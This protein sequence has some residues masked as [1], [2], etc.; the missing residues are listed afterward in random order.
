M[1]KTKAFTLVEVLVVIVIL[2]LLAL[3][4]IPNITKY[5][6]K[7]KDKYNDSLKDEL[8]LAGK[9]FYTNNRSRIPTSISPYLNDYVSLKELASQN[10]ISKEFLDK[11]KNNC[12]P[13]VT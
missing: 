13:K 5:T 8:L 11:N 1:K 9:D 2:A 3:L 4:I 10:Y 12:M 7:A 6:E